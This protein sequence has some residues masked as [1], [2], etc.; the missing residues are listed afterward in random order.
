[1]P[2]LA[3]PARAR[4]SATWRGWSGR[5]ASATPR[6]SRR[7][8]RPARRGRAARLERD[9][10][11][12]RTSSAAPRPTRRS[13]SS[14]P[15]CARSSGSTASRSRSSDGPAAPV[16]RSPRRSRGPT[17]RSLARRPDRRTAARLRARGHPEH[18]QR[19]AGEQAERDPRVR[20]RDDP[21]DQGEADDDEP[22][23]RGDRR[24]SV[25]E[26]GRDEAVGDLALGTVPQRPA[27]AAGAQHEERADPDHDVRDLRELEVRDPED[28]DDGRRPW[29]AR[30]RSTMRHRTA[31]ERAGAWTALTSSLVPMV[32]SPT[33][34]VTNRPGRPAPSSRPR[35]TRP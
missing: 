18:D 14:A 4:W 1:M 5:A 25:D 30:R 32:S 28:G 15:S 13:A 35:A 24:P 22:D 27:V 26:H 11:D 23:R 10:P 19:D 8:C 31:L 6:R 9:E 20:R 12:A 2:V 34:A 16:A 21:G 3:G 33:R 7:P 29:R 17:R